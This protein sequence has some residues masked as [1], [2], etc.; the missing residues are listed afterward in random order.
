MSSWTKGQ[1]RKEQSMSDFN[2]R[3][4]AEATILH[5]DWT[6]NPRWAGIKRPYG[7]EEV[8]RLRGSVAVE[9]SLAKQGA[10]KFW[11][12]IHEEEYVNALGAVTGNQAIQMVK[13]GLKAI[14]LS[15][16]Q[17]AGDN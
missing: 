4:Q 16:W 10:E 2:E 13:A 17:V 3:L 8:A 14:Y 15:G 5:N 7:A 9:H 12:L 1:E 11:S 6:T